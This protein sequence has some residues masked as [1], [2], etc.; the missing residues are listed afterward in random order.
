MFQGTY[1]LELAMLGINVLEFLLQ[2]VV[3]LFFVLQLRTNSV[4]FRSQLDNFLSLLIVT[5]CLGHGV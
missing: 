4:E 3:A 5:G 1:L 2:L